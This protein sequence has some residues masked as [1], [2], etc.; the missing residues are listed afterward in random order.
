M[1]FV[2]N[3]TRRPWGRRLLGTVAL[4]CA[5]GGQPAGFAAGPLPPHENLHATLW[6][7]SSAEWRALARQAYRC[8]EHCLD[9]ALADPRWTATLEQ[10]EPY[11]HLPPAVIVDIDETVLDN[12]YYEAQL[13]RDRGSYDASTWDPW[14][15]SERATPV[16][17]A[18]E[19]LR[20][21]HER[22]VSVFY[23][24]N[25][26]S[27]LQESTRRNLEALGFPLA[28][29]RESVF[30]RTDTRDKGP[31][32]AAIAAHYRVLLLVGDNNDD[33]ASDFEGKTPSERRALT[34]HFAERWGSQWIV[35][36]NPTYGS[37]EG[38]VVDYEFTA[39]LEVIFSKK[40]GELI[41][42]PGEDDAVRTVREHLGIELAVH[43]TR[44]WMPALDSKR[45]FGFRVASVDAPSRAA[46]AKI[47]AGD[48]V[49]ECNGRPIRSVIEFA[50]WLKA[51]ARTDVTFERRSTNAANGEASGFVDIDIAAAPREVF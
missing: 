37:W 17:G 9:Q 39:P 6:V 30:T 51:A 4:I 24:T 10:T 46:A 27:H 21:A 45:P 16:P 8:A 36:P 12:S 13:I 23:V 28:S 2:W 11:A 7:Q 47:R 14:V 22:G 5:A 32:R 20:S 35:I 50:A 31:R 25:R 34:D 33:F 18:L 26:K 40:Y 3:M 41:F 38:A 19:F 29:D 44:S 48:V 43:E 49:L 1:T 42:E 15:L